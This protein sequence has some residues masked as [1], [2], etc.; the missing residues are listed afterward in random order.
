MRNLEAWDVF[1]N[2]RKFTTVYYEKG[3]TAKEVQQSLIEH[4]NY[5]PCIRVRKRDA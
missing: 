1:S 4:D 3:M 2:G 5:N